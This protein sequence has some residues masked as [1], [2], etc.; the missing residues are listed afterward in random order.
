MSLELERA[1]GMRDPLD[2][3]RLA[4]RVIVHRINAP[5]VAGAVML[6]VHNAVHHRI[7]QVEIRRRH[8]DLRPQNARTIG[9]FPRAHA[10][11]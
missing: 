1:E 6:G 9:K 11:E 3:I 10:L 7:A 8:I 5:L 2:G 4:V